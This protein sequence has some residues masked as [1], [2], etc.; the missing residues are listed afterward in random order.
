[1]ENE[2]TLSDLLIDASTELKNNEMPAL[3]RACILGAAAL[4]GAPTE[5]LWISDVLTVLDEADQVVALAEGGAEVVKLDRL[6]SAMDNIRV[7]REPAPRL[8]SAFRSMVKTMANINMELNKKGLS[9]GQRLA[10]VEGLCAE[11]D[12]MLDALGVSA[13]EVECEGEGS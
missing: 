8:R 3:A 13:I 4:G 10:V 9:D 6:K 5:D 12:N 2:I 11:I 7:G 1:M